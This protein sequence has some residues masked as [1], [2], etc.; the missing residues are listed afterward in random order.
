MG[1]FFVG[2]I[3]HGVFFQEPRYRSHEA[4]YLLY[5]VPAVLISEV[6]LNFSAALWVHFLGSGAGPAAA[7]ASMGGAMLVGLP[8]FWLLFA[9]PRFTLM[10]KNFTWLTLSS[11]MALTVHE[12]WRLLKDHP[13]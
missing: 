8:L 4:R 9:A 13:I 12:F 11:A 1:I 6:M 7:G 2:F 5:L 3:I 10:S